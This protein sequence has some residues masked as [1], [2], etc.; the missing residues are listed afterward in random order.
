MAMNTKAENLQ[1][2]LCESRYGSGKYNSDR[3]FAE[4]VGVKEST[5]YKWL[6]GTPVWPDEPNLQLIANYYGI[7]IDQ[8][9]R[10]VSG[11][12]ESKAKESSSGYNV[13]TLENAKKIFDR[14]PVDD[15]KK[16]ALYSVQQSIAV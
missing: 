7:S 2:R 15:K 16:F 13:A 14:L 4:A 10:E 11:K 1:K 8:L 5:M 12:S 9:T 6:K 3:E